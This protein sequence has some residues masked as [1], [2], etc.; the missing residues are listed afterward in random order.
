MLKEETLTILSDTAVFEGLNY[1]DLKLISKYAQEKIMEKN[2]VV[3]AEGQKEGAL[4]VVLSGRVEV[5]LL[6]D[7][8]RR[9]RKRFSNVTLNT[10][11]KYDCFGEYSLIDRKPASASVIAAEKTELFTLTRPNFEN[12][13]NASDRI[14]RI[15]YS[16]F[17]RILIGRLRRKDKE[18]DLSF[19]F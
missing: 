18:L 10:L 6:Q 16:N 8:E 12:L 17:L 5:M 9:S 4:Y 19:D 13:V 3:I 11:E 2:D 1:A 14:A 15:I 7:K